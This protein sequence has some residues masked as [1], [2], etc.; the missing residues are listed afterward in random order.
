MLVL[1]YEYPVRFASLLNTLGNS[2]NDTT[3]SGNQGDL[4]TTTDQWQT[5]ET[6]FGSGY[7]KAA[8]D[9]QYADQTQRSIGGAG[10]QLSEKMSVR[11][12]RK[13][14]SQR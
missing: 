14:R 4:S 2:G 8:G 7:A 11:R 12:N 13:K 9:F 6:S 1:N 5:Q 10:D 3:Q